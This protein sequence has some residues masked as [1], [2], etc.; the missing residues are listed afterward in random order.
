VAKQAVFVAATTECE[1]MVG[2]EMR[3]KVLTRKLQQFC[4]SIG[5]L[6][7]VSMYAFRRQAAQEAKSTYSTEEAM[8]QVDHAPTNPTSMLN[9]DQHGFGRRDVT[10]FRLGGVGLTSAS[11]RKFFSQSNRLVS[12]YSLRILQEPPFI[13]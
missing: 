9:Y 4:L 5:I 6:C 10:S 3:S 7:Y 11:I 13:Y 8:A 1:L 2:K 12:T